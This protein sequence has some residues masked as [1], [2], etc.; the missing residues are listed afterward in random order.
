MKKRKVVFI[1]AAVII[2]FIAIYFFLV[3]NKSFFNGKNPETVESPKASINTT[4]NKITAYMEEECKKVYSPYYELLSFDI[5]N[6][7]EYTDSGSVE[8]TFFYKVKSKNYYKDPDTVGYIKE[9]K[10]NGDSSYQSLYDDYLNP[11][12][13]NFDLKATIDSND[14][15][16]LYTNA[17]P[18][19]IEWEKVQMSDFIA[20]Q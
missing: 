10:E 9:A 4:Y 19:G 1:I 20:P 5:S 8:A 3:N 14:L 17:S 16:T 15:I 12:E 13:M 18:N 7:K 2:A 11:H 6:Y